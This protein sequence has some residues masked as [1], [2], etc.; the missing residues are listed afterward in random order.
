MLCGTF[1]QIRDHLMDTR[2]MNL[3]VDLPNEPKMR[4]FTPDLF[5]RINSSDDRE[6]DRAQQEWEDL[7]SAYQQHLGVLLE[8]KPVGFRQL[9]QLNLHDWEVIIPEPAPALTQSHTAW[10]LPIWSSML[11]LAVRNGAEL[12]ALSYTTWNPVR[13]SPPES[14]WP[15]S[16]ER[17]H[18]LYDE[19]DIAG[20]TRDQ[21]VHRIL[22][23][24]GSLWQVPF[25]ESIIHHLHLHV[26]GE[27][28]AEVTHPRAIHHRASRK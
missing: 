2:S 5:R 21:F 12:L 1:S 11:M 3:P 9:A 4:F 22:L 17:K 18:W 26:H 27:A 6:V 24:D 10:P 13:V 14:N 23:S 16:K 28:L 20:R 7:V 15:F 19:L 8:G 25:T